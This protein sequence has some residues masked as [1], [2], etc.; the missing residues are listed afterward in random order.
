MPQSYG[1]IT[2]FQQP[3]CTQGTQQIVNR[4]PEVSTHQWHV[5]VFAISP[6]LRQICFCATSQCLHLI[7]SRSFYLHPPVLHGCMMGSTSISFHAEFSLKV[8]MCLAVC[9]LQLDISNKISNSDPPAPGAAF[10]HVNGNGVDPLKD[11]N[12]WL[13]VNLYDLQVN[14]VKYTDKTILLGTH[15]VQSCWLQLFLFA[16]LSAAQPADDNC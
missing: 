5:P 11:W 6:F 2:M 3:R 8:S 9:P 13:L 7:Q 12:F 16:L 10:L 1:Q 15:L 14:Q 4:N